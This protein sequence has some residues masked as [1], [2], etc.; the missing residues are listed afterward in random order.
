MI[1]YKIIEVNPVEHSIV[2]RFYSDVIT[3]TMLAIQSDDA[4]NVL[5]ARTDYSID[6]P[7]PAPT[8]V[9]LDQLISL[10]APT[11]WLKAQ[12]DIL[13]PNINTSMNSILPLVGTV[14]EYT[15]P[16]ERLDAPV[17]NTVFS[18]VAAPV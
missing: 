15:P 4:G 13:N 7:I 16:T 3:E 6:L 1:K 9:E 10:C 17:T 18:M 8:G 5:R 11:V 2:V 12:E 14:K